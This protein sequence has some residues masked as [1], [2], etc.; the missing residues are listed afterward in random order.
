MV[1]SSVPRS[2]ATADDGLQ[3]L[4][5]QHSLCALN[6]W[7]CR[8]HTT[9]H[10]HT[11]DTQIDYVLT[12][13]DTA[14][15]QAREAYPDHLFPVGGDR[16]SQHFP[17]RASL[18]LRPFSHRRAPTAPHSTYD[19]TA[20]QL[21]VRE[22]TPLAQELQQRVATRLRE[23]DT[24]HFAGVHPH[25]NRILLEETCALFPQCPSPDQ[26]A[27]AQPTYRITARAVWHLYRCLKHPGVCTFRNIFAKWR[28]AI[29]FARASR[30][31]RRCS[32][33]HKRQYYIAQVESAAAQGDQRSLYLIVRRLSPRKRQIASRLRSEDGKLLTRE[34]ELQAIVKYGNATF[35]ALFDDHPIL[36]LAEDLPI[37]AASIA[38]ELDHLGISKAVPTPAATW[39][40]CASALGEVLGE[41]L[42]AHFRQGT[43]AA[44][45]ED[46]KD[47]SVVWIPKPNKPPQGI[48]SLRPIGLSSPASEALAGSLRT[49]LLHSLAPLMQCMPQ[50]AYASQRGTADAI[51]KAHHHFELVADLLGHARVTRFQHQAGKVRRAC[52][53]GV[54]L[55]LDL[56]KAF[57]GVNR[58]KIYEAMHSR[59]VPASVITLVQQLHHHAKYVYRVG[60]CTGSTLTSN[61]IKQGCVIA[62]YLWN[63]FSLAFLLLLQEQRDLAWIQNLLSLFADDVWG[64]WLIESSIDFCAAISD[65]QLILETLET[66]DMTI[67]FDKTA[68][69]LKLVGKDAKQLRRDHLFQKAGQSFLRVYVHGR[70]QGIPVKDQHVYLGTVVTY[71]RRL[72]RNMQH[73]LQAARTNYQGLRKLLNGSHHLSVSHR[74]RLWVACIC[75]SALYSQHVVGVTDKSLRRLTTMLT[76]HLRAILRLP[77]HLTHV[78]NSSIWQQAGLPQPGWT[79]QQALLRHQSQLQHRAASS[80]DITSAPAALAHMQ[81]LAARLEAILHVVAQ[82]LAQESAQATVSAPIREPPTANLAIFAG[83]NT[84]MFVDPM[85]MGAY[86]NEEAEIFAA[87]WDSSM[88]PSLDFQEDGRS[89]KRHRPE[90][91]RWNAPPHMGPRPGMGGMGMSPGPGRGQPPRHMHHLQNH[92]NLLGRVVLQQEE[93]ISRLRHDKNFVVFMRNDANGTLATLMRISRDWRAK[94]SLEAEQLTSPLRTVLIACMIRELMNQAQ[95]AVATED[96][97]AKHLANEWLNQE[98]HWNY[99]RWN[100]AEKRLELD[101][102]R[103]PLQHTEAIRLLTFLLKEMTGDIIQRFAASKTLAFLE[104]QGAQ[105]ATFHL[106]I[107]LRGSRALEVYEALDRLTS[108]SLTNLI[109][110][111]MKRELIHAWHATQQA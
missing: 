90:Q 11:G 87:Y 50:F 34:E 85:N 73:R 81:L 1:G 51:A 89:Q 110:V 77:A 60:T 58:S 46:W 98:G 17:I 28:L 10:S 33:D 92:I 3:A 68:I 15:A 99:R 69:L 76:K 21:A 37:A 107:S 65:I 35:A 23:V 78:T 103:A 44:L 20:L 48:S 82:T 22:H 36:P 31:L 42:T 100:P 18:P 79:I 74:L 30:T 56:S 6:T 105:V 96:S 62:P 32:K 93:V 59:G 12:R 80:P 75:S 70:E 57:D 101:K 61:G 91:Q 45:A 95:Q 64:A 7:H 72:E 67:N 108:C 94:K 83:E 41:T 52:T 39:K 97:R 4:L 5:H 19:S 111:S 49:Q 29:Q 66:L 2:T 43:S 13:Q 84:V 16:L 25:V 38:A 71:T 54:G 14:Q 106:E 8:P 109:G 63:Y 40:L 9:F 86:A 47:C 24:Q 102:K 26:R 55:S 53:G 104:Q 88:D 27:S